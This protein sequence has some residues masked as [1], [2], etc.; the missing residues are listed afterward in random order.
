[1][2]EAELVEAWGLFLGNSQTALGLF[3]SVLTGYLIIAYLV[4]DKLTRTQVL[5]LT[6]IYVCATT[7]ISI[8]FYAWWSR[9]LEFAMEAKQLNPDRQVANNAQAARGITL[10]LFMAIFA[11]L[12]FM[13]GVRRKKDD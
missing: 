6:V 12:Y 7:I 9:A 13:W 8:W 5:I 2:T 1:M 4:G 3:L 11:S 10:M